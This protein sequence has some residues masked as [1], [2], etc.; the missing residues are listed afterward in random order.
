MFDEMF[1]EGGFGGGGGQKPQKPPDLF[2][3][4]QSHV[5]RLGKPKFPDKKSSKHMW[6]ILFYANDN[7]ESRTIS[8]KFEA[9]AE[10]TSIPYKVGAVDCKLSP[11]EETF[12]AKK[13]IHVGTNDLPTFVFVV[14]GKLILYE[15]FDPKDSTSYSPKALH[16]FC[17]DHMPQQYVN[18]I[19][20]LA[21]VEERL[22]Q[23]KTN[24]NT[25]KLW[26]P[27]VLLLTDKYETSSMFYSLAYYYREDFVMGESRAKNL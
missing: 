20:R 17:M 3:K 19:N 6:L 15:N 27:S 25:K 9:L 14:D 2:P 1:G 11:R 10:Q 22:F 18:N 13:K 26:M 4:G 16:G 21:Q 12:C 24:T 7:Q 8:E 23:K 5:A